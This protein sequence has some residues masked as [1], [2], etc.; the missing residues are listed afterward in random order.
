M[1]QEPLNLPPVVD[2]EGYRHDAQVLRDAVEYLKLTAG[3]ADVDVEWHLLTLRNLANLVFVN[4]RPMSAVLDTRRR[5]ERPHAAEDLELGARVLGALRQLPDE[6]APVVIPVYEPDQVPADVVDAARAHHTPSAKYPG[7][8]IGAT[9]KVIDQAGNT[10][11]DW[12]GT[13]LENLTLEEARS[14]VEA[15]NRHQTSPHDENGALRYLVIDTA[16]PEL[17]AELD[18]DA[19]GEY[20]VVC[21]DGTWKAWNAAVD[22]PALLDLVGLDVRRITR[23]RAREWAAHLNAR[24]NTMEP[25]APARAEL[26][27]EPDG[28]TW[29]YVVDRLVGDTAT[30]NDG[31]RLRSLS[32]KEAEEWARKFN[33]TLVD[34]A[35]QRCH[36]VDGSLFPSPTEAVRAISR[37]EDTV[38]DG[39][40][41]PTDTSGVPTSPPGVV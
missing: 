33:A 41:T 15:L 17:P 21:V 40:D 31:T 19:V 36:V 35:P 1:A 39:H 9:R 34:H 2:T 3:E 4:R 28:P 13:P 38:R 30:L 5:N 29:F 12:D 14:E 8:R 20:S 32:R 6:A 22:D 27:P 37:G 23:A 18:D 25:P 10:M 7:L 26:F 24:A 16:F 11:Q